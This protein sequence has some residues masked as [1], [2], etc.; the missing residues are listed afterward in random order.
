KYCL[1]ARCQLTK[2]ELVNRPSR[3]CQRKYAATQ[4]PRGPIKMRP[5]HDFKRS[6]G[7]P[8]LIVHLES[9]DPEAIT[10][11]GKVRVVGDTIGGGFAPVLVKTIQPVAE[12]NAL[13][14]PQEH[15]A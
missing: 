1:E 11:R 4:K 14:R 5:L 15:Y 13:L 7:D 12:L 3:S 6:F 2:T 10:S 9:R 8:F